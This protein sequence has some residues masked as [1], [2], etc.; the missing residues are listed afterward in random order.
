MRSI[1]Y[2]IDRRQVATLTFNRDQ[3]R[4]AVN[5]AAASA[6]IHGMERAERDE[7]RLVILRANP[8]AKVW[9]AGHDLSELDPE[10]LDENPMIEIFNRIQEISL[11]VIAMV[12]GSV[13]GGGLIILLAVDIAIAANNAEVAITSNKLGLPLPTEV[14]VYWLRVMGIHK[15]KELLFT[16]GALSAADAKQSGLYNHVVDPGEL[17]RRTDEIADQILQCNS[18]GLANTKYQ[19]N[20]LARRAELGDEDRKAIDESRTAILN[21]DEIQRRIAK[22]LDSLGN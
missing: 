17:E 13:H 3:K 6:L 5:R 20:L 7:A 9:C 22:L 10:T 16:A 11:P 18:A 4:N 21:S 8:G 15:T 12:E 14:Y 19:L 2:A 1:R